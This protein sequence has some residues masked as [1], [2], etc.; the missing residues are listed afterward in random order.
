MNVVFWLLVI[1]VLTA[2]WFFLCFLFKPLGRF[3]S[4]IFQDA[5]DSMFEDEAKPFNQKGES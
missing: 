2:L 5:S 1:L 4:R 3:L